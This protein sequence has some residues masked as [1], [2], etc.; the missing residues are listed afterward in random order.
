MNSRTLVLVL[1]V[2]LLGVGLVMTISEFFKAPP[3][4]PTMVPA[5][6]AELIAPYTVITQDMLKVGDEVRASEAFDKGYY[7]FDQVVGLMSTEQIS[8][9]T[10]I[11]GVQAKPI[12]KVRFVDDL[13]LEIVSFS[14]GIDRMVGGQLRPGHIINL[15]G[16]GRDEETNTD[17]TTL[18]EP[19]LWVVNVTASGRSVAIETPRPDLQT[20][21]YK[22]EVGGNT[23]AGTLITVAVEPERAFHIINALGAEGLQAWATLAANQTVDFSR[24]AT[25]VASAMP[26]ATAGLPPDLALTATAIWEAINAT[27]VAPLPR[28]GFG[29]LR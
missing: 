10:V 15:Y 4:T 25:P 3:A 27:P 29:G 13:G 2:A 17:F 6:A 22:A 1:A 8:P 12:D 26:P 28:T 16:Y 11:G 18:I 14:S 19:R 21:E 7:P 5:V 9:G 23:T 24:P 20:G